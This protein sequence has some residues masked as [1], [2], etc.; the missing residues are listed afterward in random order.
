MPLN[1]V[2]PH[3]FSLNYVIYIQ[4]IICEEINTRYI[5][6]SRKFYKNNICHLSVKNNN[7][8]RYSSFK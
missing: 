6:V 7:N 3:Y 2:E 5:L 4:T 8:T 1:T